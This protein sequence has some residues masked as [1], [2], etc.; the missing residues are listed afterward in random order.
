VEY[1]SVDSRVKCLLLLTTLSALLTVNHCPSTAES[2][3]PTDDDASDACSVL[4]RV[5]AL[6]RLGLIDGR[7]IHSLAGVVPVSSLLQCFATIH[8]R[9]A[10]Q[11]CFYAL[12]VWLV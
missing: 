1:L 10:T 12:S 8:L 3:T 2:T 7:F 9:V 4:Q 5:F 11:V 6:L